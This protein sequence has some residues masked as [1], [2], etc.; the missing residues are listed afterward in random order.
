VTCRQY[1]TLGLIIPW[2]LLFNCSWIHQVAVPSH[3]Y[4]C[5]TRQ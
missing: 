3:W 2:P 4:L 5:S 1:Y